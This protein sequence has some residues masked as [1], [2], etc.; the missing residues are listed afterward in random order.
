MAAK[1]H[2]PNDGQSEP[3]EGENGGGESPGTSVEN[4]RL[5]SCERPTCLRG[6]GENM[7][8]KGERCTEKI[9]Q[10][11]KQIF[12]GKERGCSSCE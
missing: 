10:K 3:F 12:L 1:C 9:Y 5:K 6:S 11:K 2:S 4:C 7:P 8:A